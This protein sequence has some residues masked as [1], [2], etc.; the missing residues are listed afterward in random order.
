MSDFRKPNRFNIIFILSSAAIM[1]NPKK[2]NHIT[3][4]PRKKGKEVRIS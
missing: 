3:T 2:L 4:T 1:A